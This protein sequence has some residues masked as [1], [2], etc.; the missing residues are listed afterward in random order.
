MLCKMENMTNG[1][2]KIQSAL[3]SVYHKEKIAPVAKSLKESGV[4]IYSTGG[5]LTYLHS[6]GVEA[7]A[8]ETLTHYPSI[9]GGRVKTL[10]PVV[11]GGILHRR[12]E[13]EDQKE[14]QQY[15]IPPIDLVVV[16]L[17][18]FEQTVRQS[19]D[20]KEIIEKIDIGGVSL[21]RAAAKNYE[22]VMCLP[23]EQYYEEFLEL[24]HTQGGVFTRMQRRR[25]ATYAFLV[26]AQ[27]D[28]HIFNYFNVQQQLP[29]LNITENKSVALRYGE[30]PHQWGYY[31]GD[32][33]VLFDQL[34]GKEL[35]YN[36]L[37]DLDAALNLLDEFP[38]ICPVV[39]IIKHNNACGLAQ[40]KDL[41]EA[42]KR[43]LAGDPV[44]AFGGIIVTNQVVD[45][46]AAR[47]MHELF[48]EILAAP[49]YEAEALSLLSVKKNRIIL[50]RKKSDKSSVLVRS[51]LNGYL[52]QQRDTVTED[53]QTGRVVTQ[54]IPTPREEKDLLFAN[55]IVKHTKSNAIV[56]AKEEQMIGIGTG[57]TSRVD[58]L[59]QA[60]T[61]ASSNGF[62]L[63]GSV[64]ASDAF[65]P[66][67]DCV[68]IAAEAGISAIIQPGGSIRDQES[69]EEANKRGIAMIF[70]GYR[71]FRH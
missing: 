67:P 19:G 6:I 55:R 32:F 60:I 41:S 17:Y 40:G 58:A 49:D 5:T 34:N 56:L 35:S 31:Y 47:Q 28:A 23:H 62:D 61:K 70:T 71:H 8:V 57:Q 59:K 51:A 21:L 25:F 30:N 1:E 4:N 26:T 22:D 20:E 64:M 52:V 65:F 10:H 14:V 36:N 42:W 50:R 29:V 13:E 38:A 16:D 66:F 11:F 48:F 3:I 54:K 45:V 46:A 7:V 53:S 69:I 39:A 33:T 18:P 12:D 44:S 37:L 43:A 63:R 68:Q 2:K 27:Y 24:Y 9:F 15:N